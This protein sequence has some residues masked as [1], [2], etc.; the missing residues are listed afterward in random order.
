MPPCQNQDYSGMLKTRWRPHGPL[1]EVSTCDEVIYSGQLPMGLARSCRVATAHFR[2]PCV[3]PPRMCS[4]SSPT[5]AHQQ[6]VQCA[7]KE[8]W[9]PG[10]PPWG[11][12]RSSLRPP[13]TFGRNL[14]P[15]FEF[16]PCA[17]AGPRAA[18]VENEGVGLSGVLV[19][20]Q[21][22]VVLPDPHHMAC[23][24][25]LSTHIKIIT[26]QVPPCHVAHAG[27]QNEV[28]AGLAT[29]RFNCWQST[30]D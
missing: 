16:S 27:S 18:A 5:Q 7:V 4:P 2:P 14:R 28:I 9:H 12:A 21:D 22:A 24:H 1:V 10:E 26:C 8:I 6:K 25:H 23:G 3:E 17:L 20:A 13:F 19:S 29:I 30:L 15:S 11:S